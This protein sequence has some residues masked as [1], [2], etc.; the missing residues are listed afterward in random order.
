QVASIYS[1]TG[2]YLHRVKIER[3]SEFLADLRVRLHSEKADLLGRVEENG[4]LFG[5]DGE[6]LGKAIADFVGGFG[7][8]FRE[9]GESVEIG[10]SDRIKSEKEREAPSRTAEANET[11]EEVS[12]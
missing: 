10:E 5:D 6:E 7:A 11:A 4:Q 3:V 8:D 9:Q 1:G 2:G 12:V